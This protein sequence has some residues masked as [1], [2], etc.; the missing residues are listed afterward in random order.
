[1]I[2]YPIYGFPRVSFL[3]RKKSE[4]ILQLGKYFFP[5]GE[6]KF[7]SLLPRCTPAS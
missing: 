6:L 7:A 5:I 1:M 4:L 3:K 2:I